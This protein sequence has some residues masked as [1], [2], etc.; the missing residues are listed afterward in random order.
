MSIAKIL[1]SACLLFCIESLSAQQSPE[2]ISRIFFEK[3]KTGQSDSAL[4]YLF[5]T[6]KF[7][8]ESRAQTENLK[9]SLKQVFSLNG[10]YFGNELLSKKT[11]GSCVVMLTF[12]VKQ[13]KEPLLFRLSFYK[14]SNTWEISDFKFTSKIDE[15]L[16]E[17]SR[18]YRLK[19][20]LEY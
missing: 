13:E 7:S 3:Y 18:V 10:N 14:L 11:A 15:E 8:S 19:E 17:A 12:L 6:N 20:N 1:F 9:L 16:E 5:N 2:D 4:D